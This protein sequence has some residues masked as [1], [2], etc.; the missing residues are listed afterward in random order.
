[1][2]IRY[3]SSDSKEFEI[4]AVYCPNEE[5]DVWVTYRNRETNQE[6]SCRKE[7]FDARFVALQAER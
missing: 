5:P 3:T 6:Y 4:I 1:M 7:A 2:T